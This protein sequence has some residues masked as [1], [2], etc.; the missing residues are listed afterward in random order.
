M[1]IPFLENL[2]PQPDPTRALQNYG[3]LASG[4]DSTCTR[5][6]ALRLRAVDELAL[7]PGETVFDIACGTGPTL[8]LLAARVGATGRV[9]GVELSPEMAALARRRIGAAG[10]GAS[11]E[12]IESA[13]ESLR[14]SAPADAMLFCY[15][16]DVLQS[17]PAVERL[18]ES[19]RPGARIVLLGMKTLPWSWGWAVNL[20]NMYRARR[21]LTTYKNLDRP[22][23]L[24]EARG[25]A[26]R[27]VHTALWGSAYIAVG[28][29]P[30]TSA[31]RTPESDVSRARM[32]SP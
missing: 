21:Y 26:V 29:L 22:W 28:T 1:T 9:I 6:E 5:I 13:A 30:G 31:L 19:A 20:F 23:R 27:V 8:P 2:R 32:E 7:R 17:P 18:I 4:Y 11:V 14:P 15:T 16:H 25:A 24:L 12:V 10:P 3:Q